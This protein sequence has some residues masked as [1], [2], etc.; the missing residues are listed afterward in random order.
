MDEISKTSTTEY[1]S[2]VLGRWV[3]LL[4]AAVVLAEAIWGLL[5]SHFLRPAHKNQVISGIFVVSP[6]IVR[7]ELDGSFKLSLSPHPMHRQLDW[8]LQ[9]L[10]E[11]QETRKNS[12]SLSAKFSGNA[13][14]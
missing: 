14:K 9:R 3:G 11:T 2:L 10:L 6:S 1:P 5:V 8:A 4:V 7:V 13:S 12:A